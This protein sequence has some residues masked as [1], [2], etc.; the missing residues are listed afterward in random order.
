MTVGDLFRKEFKVHDP[1]AKWISSKY[2]I[3]IKALPPEIVKYILTQ[4]F[5]E[6]LEPR[7]GKSKT[8]RSRSYSAWH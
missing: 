7:F 6:V 4:E 3:Q 8:E 5:S 2:P 1:K